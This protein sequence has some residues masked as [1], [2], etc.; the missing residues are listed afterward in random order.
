MKSIQ[1]QVVEGV[2]KGR[3]YR[4]LTVPVSIGREEGNV[5]RLND[6]RVSRFH[7]KV[8]FDGE[9]V[10]I[11]DLESTNGTR[12]N[13]DPVQIRRLQP[14]DR[15]GIGRS[16]LVFGTPDEIRDRVAR[17]RSA[18]RPAVVTQSITIPEAAA[19]TDPAAVLL[20]PHEAPLSDKFWANVQHP[21]ALPKKLHAAQAAR[22]T[23]IL[24]FMHR[25]I[26]SAAESVRVG[27]QGEHVSLPLADWLKIQAVQTLLA[28]YARAVSDPGES[29]DA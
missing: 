14:G 19:L 28:H 4:D 1:F 21:P 10:I 8:Q 20:D 11:T 17:M 7:A 13:G 23:E 15:V 27:S 3:V 22:L 25:G 2:D 29:P 24:D 5:L 18:P 9:D 12:I 26:A 16:V 6:E